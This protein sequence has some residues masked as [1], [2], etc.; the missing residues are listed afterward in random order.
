VGCSIAATSITAVGGGVDY[1]VNMGPLEFR[2]GQNIT[3]LTVI[4]IN[5]AIPEIE[6]VRA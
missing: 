1:D 6:E 3:Q 4:I 5:D 2:E